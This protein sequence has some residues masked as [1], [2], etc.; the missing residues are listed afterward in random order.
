VYGVMCT[1]AVVDSID[2]ATIG[3]DITVMKTVPPKVELT[4]GSTSGRNVV[5]LCRGDDPTWVLRHRHFLDAR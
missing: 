3:Q 2:A 1:A 5:N 4:L